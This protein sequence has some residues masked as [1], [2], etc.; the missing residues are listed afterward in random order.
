MS[1]T[2]LIANPGAD[3]YGSDRMALESARAFVDAG[4]RVVVTV[5]RPGPLIAQLTDAGATVIELPVPVVRRGL[6][7]PRGLLTLAR[8]TVTSWGP[9]WRLVRR[10]SPEVIVVNTV[11]APL[12]FAVGRLAGCR[13]V[14]HVHEAEAMTSRVLQ[15]ALYLPLLACTSVIANSA[16]TL[17]VLRAASPAVARRATIVRNAVV[18][19]SVEARARSGPAPPVPRVLFV[20]RLSHRKGPHV[21]LEAARILRERGREVSVDLVGSVFPGNEGY[22]SSL[23]D[24]VRDSGL[25]ERVS[26]HGFQADIWGFLERADLVVVPSVLDESFGN[27]A[28]EA[29][30]GARPLIVSKIPGLM[31]ATE[32]VTSR[33]VVP[34]GDAGAVADGVERVLDGWEDYAPMAAVD[35]SRVARLFSRARYGRDLVAAVGLDGA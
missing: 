12:W 32:S 5:T 17:E 7:S 28:V 30:L 18:G 22:E 31:E 13:V 16:V 21:V 23:R 10:Y 19:P 33:V 35:A 3:L 4:F 26:F 20:G 24:Q 27:T 15:A 6:L 14:C 2:V 11:T 8:Q 25:S 34:P 1:A 29:A 9:M